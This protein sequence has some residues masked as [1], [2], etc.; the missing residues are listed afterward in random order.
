[1]TKILVI[2]D[3]SQILE[4]V[5]EFLADAGYEV[6]GASDGDKGVE[7]F[8]EKSPDLVITDIIMPGKEGIGTLMDIKNQAPDVKAI[9][10]SG[11]GRVVRASDALKDA[12]FF[13]AEE[14]I[15]K[16]FSC[17]NLLETVKKVLG[18]SNKS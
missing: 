14:I 2:D 4:M 1:M 16:P 5:T 8:R 10:I 12:S 17:D 9:A 18:E 7:L 15:E 3:D 13:G 11:G 6:F